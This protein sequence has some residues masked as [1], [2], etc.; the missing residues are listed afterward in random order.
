MYFWTGQYPELQGMTKK[1]AR[2]VVG[3]AIRRHYKR[4]NL[5]FR[6]VAL[7]IFLLGVYDRRINSYLKLPSWFDLL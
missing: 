1:A 7:S 3:A 5:R 6:L 4:G 2:L